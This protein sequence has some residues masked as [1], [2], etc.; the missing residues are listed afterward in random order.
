LVARSVATDLGDH[1][2][3]KV[4]NEVLDVSLLDNI[5]SLRY[6]LSGPS[7]DGIWLIAE[8]LWDTLGRTLYEVFGS[9]AARS[10][11]ADLGNHM[12]KR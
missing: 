8:G 6:V 10:V 7:D 9:A 3:E 5:E 12:K 4:G 2:G 1:L 11:A